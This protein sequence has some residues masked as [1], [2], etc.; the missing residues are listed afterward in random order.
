MN[1]RRAQSGGRG[2]S[3]SDLQL[4]LHCTEERWK[5][6]VHT[7]LYHNDNNE[8]GPELDGPS[9]DGGRGELEGGI[10][11]GIYGRERKRVKERIW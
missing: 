11:R 2:G 9:S 10:R 6:Q 7:I 1:G 5:L 3:R 8:T 4:A